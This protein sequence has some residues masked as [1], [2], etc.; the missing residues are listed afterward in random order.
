MVV[1]KL[2]E[3][4]DI[5]EDDVIFMEDDYD[6]VEQFEDYDVLFIGS[7]TW[8]Q[9]DPHFEWVDP[10]LEIDEDADFSGKKVA[11]FGAGDSV[12]HG[13]HFCSALGKLYDVFTKKGATPIGSIDKDI[14]K[15]EASLAE[16][17]GMFC[18]L[19]IDEHN[20]KEKTPERIELWIEKLKSDLGV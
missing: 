13:E 18:G 5:D 11:F 20:E 3:E 15:Y 17:D 16:K 9:G 12:K 10:M 8:G 2:V 4:F 19:G 7:S 6:D 1:D 14:Y